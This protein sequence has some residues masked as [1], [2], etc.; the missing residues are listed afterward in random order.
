[1]NAEQS[2]KMPMRGPTESPLSGRLIRLRKRAD[3]ALSRC[4]GIV[5]T[6]CTP[7]KRTQHGKPLDVLRRLSNGK[8]R[9]LGISTLRDRVCMTAVRLVLDPIFEADLPPEQ[10]ANIILATRQNRRRW[11]P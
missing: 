7:G 8:L 1:M 5:A 11:A 3:D 10:Y 6:A 4:A 9:P 2:S